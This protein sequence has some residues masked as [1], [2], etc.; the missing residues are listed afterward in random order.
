MARMF[1]S[2]EGDNPN[3]RVGSVY[4]NPVCVGSQ[5]RSLEG[6]EYPWTALEPLIHAL[7]ALR[8]NVQAQ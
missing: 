7:A 5:V 4:G 8:E 1:P 2:K 3:G 6:G